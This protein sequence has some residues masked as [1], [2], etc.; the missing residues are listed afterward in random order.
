MKKGGDCIDVL[1]MCAVCAVYGSV[2]ARRISS[3]SQPNKSGARVQQDGSIYLSAGEAIK[4]YRITQ[5]N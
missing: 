4:G 1:Y 3:S 2:A 5:K